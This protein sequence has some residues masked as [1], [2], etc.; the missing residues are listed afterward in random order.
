MPRRFR[1]DFP[2]GN[3]AKICLLELEWSGQNMHVTELLEIIN[4][5]KTSFDAPKLYRDILH[6]RYCVT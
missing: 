6:Y 4:K 1:L 2:V 5:T 3:L